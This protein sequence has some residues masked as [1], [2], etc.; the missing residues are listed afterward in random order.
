[1]NPLLDF[2]ALPRFSQIKPEHVI[3][4]VDQLLAEN[5]T[6]VDALA[7]SA[8]APTW[9]KFVQPMEDANERLSRAWGTGVALE[10]RD[11]QC[12]TA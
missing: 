4:A 6:L 10:Q 9:A 5:K 3:P 2:S 8:E 12:R 11:E 7:A 1:M